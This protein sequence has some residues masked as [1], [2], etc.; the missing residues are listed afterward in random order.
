MDFQSGP[1]TKHQHSLHQPFGLGPQ[2]HTMALEEDWETGSSISA[3]SGI[4]DIDA[5][6][7]ANL[8]IPPL[9]P[10]PPDAACQGDKLCDICK[11]LNLTPKSFVVLEG[12]KEYNSANEPD[13]LNIPLGKVEVI[14]K[15]TNCPMCRLVLVALG[16]DKV[17][18]HEEGEPVV[19]DLSWTTDGPNPDAD[20]PWNHTPEIRLLRPYARTTSGDFIRSTTLNL[21]PEIT[22][23]AN[24]S[25]TSS[26]SYFVRPIP[27]DNIDFGLVRRWLAIC[28]TNHQRSC[29]V[30]PVLKEL[31]RSHPTIEIPE[32]RCIDVEQKCL[33]QLGAGERYAALSYVWG[34]RKF[35]RTLQTNVVDLER[36]GALAEEEYLYQIPPTI[37][38]AIHVAQEIGLRYLWVD[39]LCIVQDGD[40]EHKGYAIKAMD[41]VYAAADI[42]IVAAGSTDAYSGIRGIYP[43]SRGVRQPVEEIPAEDNETGQAFRLAFKTRWQDGIGKSPYYTRGWTY[44]ETHFATRSLVFLDGR[45]TFKCQADSDWQEDLFEPKSEITSEAGP[46]SSRFDEDDIGE[47]EGLIQTFS[48]RVLSFDSDIYNAF[49]GVSRQLSFRMQST[50]VHGIPAR[51]FDWFLLWYPLADQT[52][53]PNAPSWSW[54]GWIGGCFPR[55]WDWYE[56]SIPSVNHAIQQRTWIIW[57]QRSGHDSETCTLIFDHGKGH[58][59]SSK[60]R[61]FYG[62]V[63]HPRFELDCARTEPTPKT[64]SGGGKEPPVY[65]VDILNESPGSGFLQFWTVSITLSLNEP[66]STEED[67]GPVHSRHRLGIYGHSGRELGTMSVHSLWLEENPV[68]REREFILICEGRDKRAERGRADDDEQ[69]WRYMVMLIDWHGEYAERVAIGSIGKDDLKEALG[70]GIV[71]KEIIL[72]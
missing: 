9:L 2:T 19:V 56:R 47:Y 38:D 33:V 10:V 25:P 5:S 26:I 65:S 12:D 28:R 71:W 51:Y 44:Q 8:E 36:P 52:R 3:R 41:L 31:K 18:F 29:R 42:V 61:N 32:F 67:N 24:D 68:P 13:E 70:R 7:L 14:A 72:G 57:Y 30:N 50:L 15:K 6:G 27:R 58:K 63:T 46:G 11:D 35:F 22:L 23:L 1:F 66:T 48:D 64:L 4:A 39:S 60:T 49:A 53:R 34:R 21:F 69:G 55:I 16:G 54:S 40:A 59:E 62:A 37:R 17:P 45:V 20:A 43:G